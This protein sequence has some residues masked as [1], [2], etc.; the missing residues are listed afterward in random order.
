MCPIFNLN[1]AL[2]ENNIKYFLVFILFY[3][4]INDA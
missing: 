4:E 2:K 3:I 1:V